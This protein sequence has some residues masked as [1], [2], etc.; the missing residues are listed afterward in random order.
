MSMA[1]RALIRLIALAALCAG[2][3]ASQCEL[4]AGGQGRWYT[5]DGEWPRGYEAVG[6]LM[7]E[8][9]CTRSWG[10]HDFS[11]RMFGRWAQHGSA[12]THAEIRELQ[13]VLTR[14]PWQLR[15]GIDRVF[16]GV[17]EFAHIV[18]VLNQADVLEDPF[19]E[20]KS[21]Q[22][23]LA[24]S[25][26]RD[27][28]SLTLFVLPRFRE[29]IFPDP[30]EPM[31]PAPPLELGPAVFESDRERRHVDLALRYAHTRGPVDIGLAYF[32]GTSRDPS[33]EQSFSALHARYDQISQAGIDLQLTL[34]EWIFKLEGA[35]RR[36]AGRGRGAFTFGAEHAIVGV[37]GT[38]LDLTAVV[39]YV[40][41]R[42][43]PLP[44]P[45]FLDDDWAIGLRLTG[46]DAR[47]TEAKIG[48]TSDRHRDSQAWAIEV[49]TRI[50][51]HWRLNAQARLFN[52]VS[53]QD[54]LYILHGDSY[55]DLSLTRY[56]LMSSP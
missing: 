54:A 14:E 49:G 46:N 52:K 32:D 48:M 34:E 17:T 39:E 19:G 9:Y 27:W 30:G 33:F 24:V 21:G 7:S 53:T 36:R 23:L 50:G 44:V 37:A 18:D 40:R 22:P 25:S 47:T 6:S 56:F 55:F 11:A 20:V 4:S 3:H 29:R 35:H 15:A 1:G 8:L 31:R 16:W 42:R 51:A 12:R 26:R 38:P 43:D 45:G 41:D 28:G 10:N 13:W 5:D 2:A